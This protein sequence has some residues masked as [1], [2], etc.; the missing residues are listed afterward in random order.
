ML[1]GIVGRVGRVGEVFGVAFDG[2]LG[3]VGGSLRGE[4]RMDFSTR[5]LFEDELVDLMGCCGSYNRTP[6][7]ILPKNSMSTSKF[8]A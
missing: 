4:L 8:M 2:S 3:L 5:V 1:V 7:T 6:W